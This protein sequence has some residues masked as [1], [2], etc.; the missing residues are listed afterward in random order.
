MKISRLISIIFLLMEHNKISASKL[1][2]LFEVSIRTIYRD[3]DSLLIAG[4]PIVTEVG[5]NGG[6]KIEDSFK[7]EKGFFGSDEIISLLLG[8]ES[9]PLNIAKSDMQTTVAKIKNMIPNNRYQQIK[10]SV[11]QISIDYTP[12]FANNMD[13]YYLDE[14]NSAIKSNN[15]ITIKYIDKNGCESKRQLEPYLLSFKENYWYLQ[16]YCLNKKA[17]RVFKLTRVSC[18]IVHDE[19]FEARDYTPDPMNGSNWA[20][21]EVIEVKLKVEPSILNS[22]ID[23]FGHSVIQ[24]TDNKDIIVNIPLTKDDF[25]YNIILGFGYQ[26]ECIEP[27]EVRDE[28]IKR[29]KKSLEKYK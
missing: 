4:I 2:E 15:I 22:I 26:C 1:A 29:L 19:L 6:I 10:K 23:M 24:E 7:L 3:L 20:Y 17:F 11:N 16:A 12:W 5:V 28:I 18:L 8:L 25:G 21:K 14:L 13:T 27:I 9:L